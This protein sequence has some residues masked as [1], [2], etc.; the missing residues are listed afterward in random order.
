MVAGEGEQEGRAG[1]A[2]A[3]FGQRSLVFFLE[4]ARTRGKGIGE[5]YKQGDK[6]ASFLRPNE[7]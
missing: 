3:L 1:V 2:R 7:G 5:E 6:G 4:G